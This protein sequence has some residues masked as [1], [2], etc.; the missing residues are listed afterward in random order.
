MKMSGERDLWLGDNTSD[1]KT[2]LTILDNN[3][4]H[5]QIIESFN[6]QY[7]GKKLLC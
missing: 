4:L 5:T 3:S 6:N 1:N 2:L 7:G